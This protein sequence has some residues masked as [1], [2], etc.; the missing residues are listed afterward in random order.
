CRAGSTII[1]PCEGG[2]R[3]DQRMLE[4]TGGLRVAVS[5]PRV[6]RSASRSHDCARV[7]QKGLSPCAIRKQSS[8][9]LRY[10]LSELMFTLPDYYA[11]LAQL[12]S[13]TWANSWPKRS[14][15]RELLSLCLL[16]DID[17][18]LP[19]SRATSLLRSFDCTRV[20]AQ[21][22]GFD[23]QRGRGR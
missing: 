17:S 7:S 9:L 3:A 23:C 5:P 14:A 13:L 22:F 12:K 1:C 6:A 19:C 18:S 15:E 11:I 21:T 4:S 2:E 16:D 8:G 20:C 10:R